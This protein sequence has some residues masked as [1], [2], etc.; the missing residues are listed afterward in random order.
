MGT[1]SYGWLALSF[2]ATLCIVPTFLSI[3]YFGRNFQVKPEVFMT[4]YF[5]G[6]SLGVGLW[7]YLSGRATDLLPRSQGALA[8]IILIGL[9]FGA[10]ANSS[11]FRAV[12]LAPNPGMP[13]VVYSA[14]SVVVFLASAML[15]SRLPKYFE[16]VSTDLDRFL[17]ILLVIAGLFLIAG[18]W[19]LLRRA[20]GN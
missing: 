20:F 2:L 9:T 13:P 17:G 3:P 1:G 16:Q 18:G 15:A 8:G 5:A 14:V 7:I 11:L 19:P 10:V 4:W 6:V 12:A